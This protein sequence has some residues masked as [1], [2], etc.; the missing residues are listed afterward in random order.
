MAKKSKR[1]SDKGFCEKPSTPWQTQFKR[2]IQWEEGRMLEHVDLSRG[3]RHLHF[4]CG[5]AELPHQTSRRLVNYCV[6]LLDSTSTRFESNTFRNSLPPYSR[7]STMDVGF[8]GTSIEHPLSFGIF[9]FSESY[10]CGA[11]AC[12]QANPDRPPPQLPHFLCVSHMA[13]NGCYKDKTTRAKNPIRIKS[14]SFA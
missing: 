5:A 14:M 13:I 9:L 2:Q 11:L 8:L 4:R 3:A 12:Q 7:V 6:V 1:F 10:L